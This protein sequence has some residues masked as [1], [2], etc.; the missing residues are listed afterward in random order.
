MLAGFRPR[1]TDT[2]P[3]RKAAKAR[4]WRASS[5]GP[6]GT[7]RCTRTADP[8]RDRVGEE[9]S[10]LRAIADLH[11]VAAG[12]VRVAG[13]LQH[14]RIGVADEPES[15]ESERARIVLVRGDGAVAVDAA[16]I[17]SRTRPR[18]APLR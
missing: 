6:A 13:I 3:T 17:I 8:R 5:R 1:P 15:R 9:A 14:R 10:L 11:H 4:K 2:P 18:V 7:P 16:R 12:V